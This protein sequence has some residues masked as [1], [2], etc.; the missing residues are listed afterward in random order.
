MEAITEWETLTV[1]VA[2]RRQERSYLLKIHISYSWEIHRLSKNHYDT[3]VRLLIF[4]RLRSTVPNSISFSSPYIADTL[5]SFFFAY[6]DS[7][8]VI[9]D[10][11]VS[12]LFAARVLFRGQESLRQVSSR[13][14]DVQTGSSSTRAE[15]HDDKTVYVTNGVRRYEG[16]RKNPSDMRWSTD[17]MN[18]NDTR[19]ETLDSDNS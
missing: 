5:T 9:K 3:Y 4:S 19:K 15:F 7:F 8:V 16:L 13:N 12:C 11:Q 2:V 17:N 6:F 18:Q 1:V 14:I 10:V